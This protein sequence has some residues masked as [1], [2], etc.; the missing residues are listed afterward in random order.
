M[1][2]LI[3]ISLVGLVA[4]LCGCQSED[5]DIYSRQI[6]IVSVPSGAPIVVDGLR[7]GT[8]PISI[9][10]ETN[11]FGCFV[12]KTVITA[13]PQ[14]AKYHTQLIAF[15]AY[16]AADPEKSKAP[17]KITFHMEKSPADGGGVVVDEE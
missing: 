15:P 10:V 2:K 12:R 6:D 9:G 17:E 14:D 8:A 5:K 3:S 16:L 4:V 11:E 7:L 1:K 13:I